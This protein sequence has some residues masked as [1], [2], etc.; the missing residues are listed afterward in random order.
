MTIELI[1]RGE[2]RTSSRFYSE[3]PRGD[4]GLR[5]PDADSGFSAPDRTR[6]SVPRFLYV[7]DGFFA[8][9]C[10]QLIESTLKN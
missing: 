6:E 9:M 2:A 4:L 5:F 3:P 8:V 1:S 7:H 10:M